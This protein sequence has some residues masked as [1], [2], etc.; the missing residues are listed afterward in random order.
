MVSDSFQLTYGVQS[1]ILLCKEIRRVIREGEKLKH[2]TGETYVFNYSILHPSWRAI[3]ERLAYSSIN[4][5]VQVYPNFSQV[6]PS[7]FKGPDETGGFVCFCWVFF[8]INIFTYKPVKLKQFC[9]DL[10]PQ[11]SFNVEEL[12]SLGRSNK[13]QK[14]R[15]M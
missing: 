3:L 6:P 12:S 14:S 9:M 11:I 1:R 4:C 13:S 7:V 15:S 5:M 2:L 10:R 8:V